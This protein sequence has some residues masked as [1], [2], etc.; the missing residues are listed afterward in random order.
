MSAI[1]RYPAPFNSRIM[2]GRYLVLVIGTFGERGGTFR[3]I[4]G[5]YN[6]VI[7]KKILLFLYVC[8][9]LTVFFSYVLAVWRRLRGTQLVRELIMDLQATGDVATHENGRFYAV[10]PL[11]HMYT[12]DGLRVAEECDA[13]PITY[14]A[15]LDDFHFD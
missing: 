12:E 15:N 3:E 10:D 1:S 14:D 6:N 5:K 9:C 2:A 4:G 8:K 11:N 13:L 7:A